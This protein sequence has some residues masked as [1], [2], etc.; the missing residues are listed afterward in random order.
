M[1]TYTHERQTLFVDAGSTA[2]ERKRGRERSERN[3]GI[4]EGRLQL[5]TCI[6]KH[7][8]LA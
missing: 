7:M 1:G 4:E 6:Y 2:R 5:D 3:K 8:V